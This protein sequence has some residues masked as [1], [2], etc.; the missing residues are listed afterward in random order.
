[1]IYLFEY[2]MKNHHHLCVYIFCAYLFRAIQE[3]AADFSML[4][5][6]LRERYDPDV[7]QWSDKYCGQ[8]YEF[9]QQYLWNPSDLQRE[10]STLKEQD[11]KLQTENR[12]IKEQLKQEKQRRQKTFTIKGTEAIYIKRRQVQ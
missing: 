4:T 11:D 12:D 6:K 8:Y 3:F 5:Q 1:M 7:K 2:K 9:I 10:I